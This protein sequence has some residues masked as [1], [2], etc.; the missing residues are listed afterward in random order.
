MYLDYVAVGSDSGKVT[1]LEFK[2]EERCFEPVSV[3]LTV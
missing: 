3:L 1:I 2:L